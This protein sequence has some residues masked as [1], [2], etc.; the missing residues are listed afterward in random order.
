MLTSQP[1]QCIGTITDFA[2]SSN[3]LGPSCLDLGDL[4]TCCHNL[5]L[6]NCDDQGRFTN[7]A[8]S[9]DFNAWNFC[10]SNCQCQSS[11]RAAADGS[12]IEPDGQIAA[13]ST[14]SAP[15][16]TPTDHSGPDG[17]SCEKW[18]AMVG[19]NPAL[20]EVRPKIEPCP[21]TAAP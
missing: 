4:V 19:A 8:T 6:I 15:V 12:P 5:A 11:S 20:V 9:P 18:N 2:A 16:V 1:L 10:A 7:G 13:I 3:S 21:S 17:I 14:T